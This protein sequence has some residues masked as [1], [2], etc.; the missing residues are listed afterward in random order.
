MEITYLILSI[1]V[2]IFIIN[3]L[4]ALF[5]VENLSSIWWTDIIRRIINYLIAH[6]WLLK[7]I[8]VI[9]SILSAVG[10]IIF[11]RKLLITREE[12]HQK[13]YPEVFPEVQHISSEWQ[14]ILNLVESKNESDW[15]TAIIEADIILS[16]IVD[17]MALP[18]ET[19]GDKMRA[20]DKSDFVSLD[21]AWE[22]H[23]IR[24]L[25]AH[26][27]SDFILTQ[28]EARRVIDLYRTVFEEF[29]VI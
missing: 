8:S 15:R 26:E 20:I 17:K 1:F 28:R 9:L 2:F 10:I 23:K 14:R 18:G 25:I 11:L 4:I 5:A 3:G 29:E 12:L 6:L 21:N 13:L 24:N 19:M 27:G 7:L 16:R 22:A